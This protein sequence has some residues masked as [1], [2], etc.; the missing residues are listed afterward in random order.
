MLRLNGGPFSRCSSKKGDREGKRFA[1]ARV[2]LSEWRQFFAY[3]IGVIGRISNVRK[4]RKSSTCWRPLSNVSELVVTK[5]A[6]FCDCC[7]FDVYWTYCQIRWQKQAIVT[8]GL[9]LTCTCLVGIAKRDATSSDRTRYFYHFVAK[10]SAFWLLSARAE[11][12]HWSM[13]TKR[14]LW[15][16][17][18]D[19]TAWTK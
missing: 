12:N 8:S 3:K 7:C 4:L 13:T 18:D 11:Q 9:C 15:A 1:H 5:H 17:F 2:L 14:V 6:I 16:W 19:G 10:R